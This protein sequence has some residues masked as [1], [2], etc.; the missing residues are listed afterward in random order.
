MLEHSL[1]GMKQD[2]FRGHHISAIERM[3]LGHTCDT[4]LELGLYF[5]LDCLYSRRAE[6][7][8]QLLCSTSNSPGA[9]H[10]TSF[11]IIELKPS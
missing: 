6:C 1:S 2:I 7:R 4:L 11:T 3:T 10:S 9:A 5:H 8:Q